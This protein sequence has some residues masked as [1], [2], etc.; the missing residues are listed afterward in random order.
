MWLWVR[1]PRWVVSVSNV[2]CVELVCFR[3]VPSRTA[4][5]VGAISV[6]GCIRHIAAI[7]G[8][9]AI[10][11]GMQSAEAIAIADATSIAETIATAEA[12]AIAEGDLLD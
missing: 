7:A 3:I 2:D 4:G 9:I 6:A 12:I 5:P 1:A 10:A 11:K 8:A